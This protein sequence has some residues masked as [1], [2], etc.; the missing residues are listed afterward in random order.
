MALFTRK[1]SLHNHH[2]HNHPIIINITHTTLLILAIIPIFLAPTSYGASESEN[3]IKFKDSLENT[4]NALSSWN[5][6]SPPCAGDKSNWVG[7]LCAK[8]KIWGLQLEKMG[9]KGDIDVDS[10]KELPDLRTI[11]LMGNEFDSTWPDFNKLVGLKSLFLSNNKFSGSIPDQAFF[12]LKWL[13]KIHISNNHF[14]GPLP[15]SLTTLPKLREIRFDGN[16]FEG[17]IPNFKQSNLTTFNVSHNK[18][19][20]PIPSTLSRIS[21]DSFSGN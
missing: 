9:L 21:A 19:E 3:L 8:G 17:T 14:T 5:S 13:K 1:K 11:S 2:D 15:L 6:S 16:A 18:L 20:G 12:D 7:L 4:N 10:L